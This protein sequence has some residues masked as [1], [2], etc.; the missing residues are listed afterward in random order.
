MAYWYDKLS[1]PA[2]S[3]STAKCRRGTEEARDSDSDFQSL[4][5]LRTFKFQCMDLYLYLG[6]WMKSWHFVASWCTSC[7]SALCFS[8]IVDALQVEDVKYQNCCAE[9]YRNGYEGGGVDTFWGPDICQD[10]ECLGGFR[11]TTDLSPEFGPFIYSLQMWCYVPATKK[12]Y[13]NPNKIIANSDGYVLSPVANKDVD[14]FSTSYAC[15]YG[16]CSTM[17]W[18]SAK[19]PDL[20]HAPDQELLMSWRVC[21]CFATLLSLSIH[22]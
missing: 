18:I 19:L 7:G 3:Y 2:S 5:T 4:R 1:W 15:Y 22:V 14:I 10:D 12:R 21:I 20:K 9:N 16:E 17:D 8:L 6:S 13:L 11:Y